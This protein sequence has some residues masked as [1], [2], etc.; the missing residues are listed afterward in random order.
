MYKAGRLSS[1]PTP[2]RFRRPDGRRPE[3]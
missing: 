3:K 1:L 2:I